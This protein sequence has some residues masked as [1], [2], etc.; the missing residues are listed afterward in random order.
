ML[1][2]CCCILKG[3]REESLPYSTRILLSLC[4]TPARNS[5]F[6]SASAIFLSALPK[7]E[8]LI[9]HCQ[10]KTLKQTTFMN[11]LKE[12]FDS[13]KRFT[14]RNNH[15]KTSLKMRDDRHSIS[16]SPKSENVRRLSS[17]VRPPSLF[18]LLSAFSTAKLYVG[19]FS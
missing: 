1:V 17:L 8:Y 7:L 10:G 18:S 5:F 4:I 15:D 16:H 3:L 9:A 12:R 11:Y 14:R 2:Q 13:L 6:L 19:Q